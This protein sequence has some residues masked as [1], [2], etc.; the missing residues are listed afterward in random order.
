MPTA[1]RLS[2]S[3]PPAAGCS[4]SAC[5]GYLTAVAV[6]GPASDSS[7]TRGGCVDATKNRRAALASRCE[8]TNTSMTCP[9][10]AYGGQ[11]LGAELLDWAGSRAAD[12]GADWLRVDV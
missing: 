3:P 9:N 12:E 1:K 8:E 6:D 7:S 5:R 11:G 2:A 10:C 4:P